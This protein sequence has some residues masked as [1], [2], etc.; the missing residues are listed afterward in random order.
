[1]LKYVKNLLPQQ[2]LFYVM[3][4]DQKKLERVVFRCDAHHSNCVITSVS[5]LYVQ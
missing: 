5:A 3:V 1:M 2:T 4:N